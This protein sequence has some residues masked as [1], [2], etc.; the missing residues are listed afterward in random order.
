[1]YADTQ[2][3][4]S[5]ALT[6]VPESIDRTA[7]YLAR[8]TELVS[9]SLDYG[10]TVHA[11]AELAVHS[12]A[13]FCVIDL[14]ESGR[15]ERCAV[16][17]ADPALAPL[18]RELLSFPLDRNR[19]H[20]SREALQSGRTVLVP[21]VTPE[22]LDQTSQSDEH[23]WLLER[24]AP[25]SVMAVPLRTEDQTLGV[26][27]FVSSRRHYGPA[28][29]TLAE[30]LVRF[31]AIEIE[32]ARLYRDAR[33]QIEARGQLLGMVAHDLR[34]PLNTIHLT[35]D[36]LLHDAVPSEKRAEF[37]QRVL[38][39]ADRM[40]RLIGDLL[41]ATRLEADT[42]S[43]ERAPHDPVVL[44]REALLEAATLA[45]TKGIEIVP[46]LHDAL[47]P[48]NV[49]RGRIL[50]VLGNLLANAIRFTPPKGGIRLRVQ[51]VPEGVQFT[52]IDSGPG[53][54]DEDLSHLF[55]PFWRGLRQQSTDGSG[56]GLWIARGIVEVHGGRIWAEPARGRG[57]IFHFTL[58]I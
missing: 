50:Q 32:H 29:V 39:A 3:F 27:L 15:V 55:E 18:A 9:A 8:A 6:A 56:L 12:I 13:D 24:L 46:D 2:R 57:G 45:A 58:P 5:E 54:R 36:L 25:R 53:V 38:V 23:R 1:M 30:R 10:E 51:R 40:N 20:I 17:H 34:N 33:S 28:D 22:L 37:L 44:A 43:L 42:L 4:A 21:A 14:V 7:Q 52:V 16:A 47:P 41:D 48:V 35:V 49:D 26:I 19:P 31:A 11:A